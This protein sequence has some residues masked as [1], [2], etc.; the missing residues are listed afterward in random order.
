MT[1]EMSQSEVTRESFPLH[2]AIADKFGGEVLAFDQYQGPYVRTSRGKFWI[3]VHMERC[4]H[5]H[6]HDT[7][8]LEVFNEWTGAVSICTSS[9]NDV[10]RAAEEASS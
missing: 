6:E 7:G 2:F 1:G 5:G 10:V 8:L 4:D 3:Q 9:P